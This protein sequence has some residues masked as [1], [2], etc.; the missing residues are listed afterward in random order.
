VL[1]AQNVGLIARDAHSAYLVGTTMWE[2]PRG[3]KFQIVIEDDVWIGYGAIVLSGVTIGR[4]SIIA[5]GSVVIKDV[6]PYSIVVPEPGRILKQR[7]TPEQI[8][9]H[10]EALAAQGV[11]SS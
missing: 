8:A 10:E 11:I 4:G 9:E 2:S 3:D 6:P 5:A 1:I 7:F